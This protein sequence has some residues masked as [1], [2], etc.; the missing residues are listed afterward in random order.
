MTTETFH[1]GNLCCVECADDV[2]KALKANPN[3]ATARVDYRNDTVIVSYKEE[4]MKAGEIADLIEAAGHGCSMVK[5]EAGDSHQ[6]HEEAVSHVGFHG[7]RHLR[8]GHVVFHPG[9]AHCHIVLRLSVQLLVYVGG[10]GGG[11]L[12]LHTVHLGTHADGSHLRL[13]LN[14]CHR[15]TG[16]TVH[17]WWH[18]LIGCM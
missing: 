7:T 10:G 4:A 9:V 2:Q 17:D 11:H 5:A 3:V 18:Y 12:I 15:M 1:L 13:V 14:V 6:G 16:A 8:V